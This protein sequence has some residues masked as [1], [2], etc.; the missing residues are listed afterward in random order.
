MNVKL[1]LVIVLESGTKFSDRCVSISSL[2]AIF[3][4]ESVYWDIIKTDN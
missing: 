4:R 1:I 3:K 2:L